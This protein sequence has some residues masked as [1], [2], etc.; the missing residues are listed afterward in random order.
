MPAT[1]QKSSTST[2]MSSFALGFIVLCLVVY[3]LHMA[4]AIMIPFVI[5]VFVWYLINAIARVLGKIAFMHGKHLPRALCLLLTLLALGCAVWFI[6]DLI[7]MNISQV[8][9]AAPIYQQNFEKVVPK[10]MTLFGLE[11]TPTIHDLIKYIDLGGIITALA[12]T[13]TGLAGKTLVVAFYVGFLLYEQ[14]F[15]DRKIKDMFQDSEKEARIRKVLKNIDDKI[16]RYI[17]V[18]SFVSAIDSI[19]TYTILS[20]FHVDFA[21]FWGLMA[22]FLHFIPYA[23]SFVALTLPSLIALIQY[24]DLSMGFA[25]LATLSISHAF[26]GHVLDPYLMGNNLNLSPIFIISSLA[27]WGMIW[28]IPGMFMAIPILA[29][30]AITLSQFPSTRPLAILLSKTGILEQQRAK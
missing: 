7:G 4:S 1:A 12:K 3:I 17:G 15:F 21:G 26:I 28:G 20:A 24:G 19:L 16:Q 10:V 27:M 9:R 30:I 6:I 25:V 8:M 11:H 23:G 2:L 14:R 29:T 22:F 5:A 18:K 13:F